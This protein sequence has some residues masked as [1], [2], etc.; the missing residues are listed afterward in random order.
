[1]QL[2]NANSMTGKKNLSIL[3]GFPLAEHICSEMTTIPALS[4]MRK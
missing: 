4:A 3:H 2:M 1:M